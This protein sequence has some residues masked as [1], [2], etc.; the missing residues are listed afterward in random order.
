MNTCQVRL[1]LVKQIA[2]Y[3]SEVPAELT[4]SRDSIEWEAGV[5]EMNRGCFLNR[6]FRGCAQGAANECRN[7]LTHKSCTP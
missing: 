7:V 1:V 6:G 4:V 5:P 3:Q 2:C